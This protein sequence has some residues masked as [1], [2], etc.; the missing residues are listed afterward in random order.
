MG[1]LER[2]YDKVRLNLITEGVEGGPQP[3]DDQEIANAHVIPDELKPFFL[4]GSGKIQTQGN[5]A[6]GWGAEFTLIL[7]KNEWTDGVEDIQATYDYVEQ[8]IKAALPQS[9]GVAGDNFVHS[10][11]IVQ[12]DQ[13]TDENIVVRCVLRGGADI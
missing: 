4:P 1:S 3:V 8:Q 7:P 11:A 6:T 12:D 5:G 13:S 10:Y 9:S 2:A